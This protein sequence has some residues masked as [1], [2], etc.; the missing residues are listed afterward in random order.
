MATW[1]DSETESE[2]EIDTAYMCFMAHGDEAS[3]VKLENSLENEDL[4]MDELAQFFEELQNRYEIFL[5]NKF[6]IVVNEKND[7]SKSFEKIK[8]DFEK[9]K[10]TYKGKSPNITYN[11]NKFLDI[12]KRIEVLDTTLKKCAFD[13]TK[14]VYII[15]KENNLKETHSACITHTCTLTSTQ[16]CIHVWKNIYLCIL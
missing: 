7:L 14:F 2:E 9:Y 8:I 13:M 12:Q 5:K 15:P 10:T 11:K 6:E 4:I 1:D 16:A 3:K